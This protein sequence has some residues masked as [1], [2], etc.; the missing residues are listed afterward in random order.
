M[1]TQPNV[2]KS[3]LT[4][5]HK[6]RMTWI[7]PTVLFGAIGSFYAL[8]K[9]TKW[10]ASQAM[11]VR[12]EAIGEISR[13]GSFTS[14]DEM[15]AAQEMILEVAKN[16]TVIERALTEIRPAEDATLF[17]AKWP[18]DADITRVK[19]SISVQA[20]KGTEFGK[21][22]VIYL[23]VTERTPESAVELTRAM[24]NQLDIRLREL[25]GRKA[26][27]V[28]IEL[29][30]KL[31]LAE[32]NLEGVTA[33]LEQM[34][35]EVG[36]DLGELRNLNDSSAG[37]SNLRRSLTQIKNEMR[38]S[39]TLAVS[40]K[41]QLSFL[42]AANMAPDSFVATPNQLLVSQP[43]LRR[44]KDGL[45]DA[46]LRTAD[47]KGR[48]NDDHPDVQAALAAE[49]KVR[50]ELYAELANAIN[51][52][53]ADIK[54]NKALTNSLRKQLSDVEGRLGKLASLR[55]RYGNLVADVQ[56]R[57]D[58]VRDAKLA[59]ANARGS[60]E[61]SNSASLLTL[62]DD[63]YAGNSPVG[64]GRTTIVAGSMIMGAMTGLGLILLM[65][66][67]LFSDRR[68]FGRRAAD[69]ALLQ[70]SGMNQR[71][72]ASDRQGDDSSKS[73]RRANDTAAGDDALRE[74]IR[75]G[76]VE[77]DGNSASKPESTS[78]VQKPAIRNKPAATQEQ[79]STVRKKA[80]DQDSTKAPEK[81]RPTAAPVAG[82]GFRL[83]APF[84]DE[85]ESSP[86]PSSLG[87]N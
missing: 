10:R 78:Q 20:P 60:E 26:Q 43:A 28:I 39:E 77:E 16:R 82:A 81:Q 15:K 66:P 84:G 8:T 11:I 31:R 75:S 21:S 71:R 4:A 38:Q 19:K 53:H 29:K 52:V 42:V 69:K 73:R 65:N 70:E 72:R 23:S 61:A 13:Q 17:R 25:R 87:R 14:M 59:L 83:V 79:K 57:S 50:R 1:S 22:E 74:V 67:G 37:D 80:S 46:Q 62:V 55:A 45:V 58:Q 34:E 40:L 64:P 49:N 63:P 6:N 32:Q 48:M 24:S 54:V 5:V 51:G 47:L 44:L 86:K 3:L 27:S 36:G 30:Q 68:R 7:L 41:E 33:R 9:E 76:A 2:F 85:S 35:R 18:R 12:D 56:H